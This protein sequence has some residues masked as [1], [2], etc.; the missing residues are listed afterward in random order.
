MNR[1]AVVAK[2]L[3]G[4]GKRGGS[5]KARDHEFH[6]I[7]VIP[8]DNRSHVNAAL[9]TQCWMSPRKEKKWDLRVG[10]FTQN[11]GKHTP[12]QINPPDYRRKE[13]PL[14]QVAPPQEEPER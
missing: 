8:C 5:R 11:I 7:F 13:M 12:R 1:S 10:L 6:D 14:Y 9:R 2:D 3:Y 4:P